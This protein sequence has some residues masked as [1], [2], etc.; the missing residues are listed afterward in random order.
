MLSA[1]LM[2]KLTT[3]V[4]ETLD[5]ARK[6]GRDA[7][8]PTQA[9]SKPVPP[10]PLIHF[11][12]LSDRPRVFRMTQTLI[13]DAKDRNK[14]KTP[15]SL[16]EDLLDLSW[17][18]RAVGLVTH[19]DV[20]INPKFPLREL[21]AAAPKLRWIHV[22]GAGIEPLLP[23]DWLPQIAVL[24]N[25][26]G[27][28]A[29]KVRES[30]AMMLLMLNSRVPAIVSNQRRAHWHQIFT[31]V[32]RGKTVLIIGVGDM[33][34]AAA[35]AARRLGLRV[36]GIRRS[37]ASH[38]DVDQMFR[39]DELDAALTLADF[40]LLSAPLTPETKL[41]IDERRIRLMKQGA[42][43]I[44]IGRAGLVDYAALADALHE[45]RLSG[46]VLDVYDPEPLPSTSPLW[47]VSNL[48]LMPHVTSDDED[49][50]LPRLT[51]CL[52]MFAD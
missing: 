14:M 5:K 52:K 9:P 13:A 22:T 15:T 21:A 19:N 3:K 50:Y 25:N 24:T 47:A 36:L 18:S 43:L 17:L 34:G 30:S 40:V 20:L 41:L 39:T 27:V 48:I 51:S 26:S 11:E 4:M 28:H 8:T 1:N 33:G 31:R 29:D 12:T 23:L 45:G 7:S 42:G 35:E 46:A 32:I 37:G 10:E 6:L 44:N 49:Q 2:H 16:G 38:P